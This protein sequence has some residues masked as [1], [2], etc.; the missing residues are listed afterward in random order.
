MMG[1]TQRDNPS[2]IEANRADIK[3]YMEQAH[4]VVELICDHLD[5]Q[6]H[7][8]KGTLARL[9]PLHVP[10]GSALRMLRYLPQPEE[11]LR[12]SLVGHTDIG[13]LTILF[14]ALGGLQLLP[15][16]ADATDNSSWVWV[17]PQPG[18]AIINL[19][20]AM[21][22]WTAGILRSN[23]HRVTF[24]PGAQ[25][26]TIRYS[27]AYLVRPFGDAPMKRLSGG[28]SLVPP[29]GE[30]EEE[31][32]MNSRDWEIH[33][34]IAIRAGKDNA[35]SRGGREINVSVAA[36]LDHITTVNTVGM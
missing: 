29:I 5:V 20:D 19:G 17:H 27:L 12:T 32:L 33:R 16:G 28:Q 3:T 7:L 8:P 34:A 26:K 11:D 25:S 6:L 31:N 24:G 2:C 9:Q 23:M 36:G 21:V 35:R 1:V 14:N 15:P 4:K 10:S 22:E 18:C 13:T 30:D